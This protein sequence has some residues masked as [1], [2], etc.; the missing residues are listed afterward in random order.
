MLSVIITLSACVL[1]CG[2]VAYL[3]WFFYRMG[4]PSP[5]RR[6]ESNS[7]CAQTD[8]AQSQILMGPVLSFYRR[9]LTLALGA[10]FAGLCF[11][12]TLHARLSPPERPI[13]PE[14]SLGYTY[15]F[16]T[17][18]GGVYGTYFEYVTVSYGIWLTGGGIFL[19]ILTAIRLKINLYDGSPAFPLL[20][21]VAS[22]TSMVLCFALWQGS[23]YFARS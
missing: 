19:A 18:H 20:I 11:V 9:I 23:L 21:F 17:K 13:V 10:L 15:L 1:L 6:I 3:R 14:A 7:E 8:L 4:A 5:W 12:G 16:N 2:T 22:T